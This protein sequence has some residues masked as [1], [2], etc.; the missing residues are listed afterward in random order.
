MMEIMRHMSIPK[1]NIKGLRGRSFGCVLFS[2]LFVVETFETRYNKK[3]AM[4]IRR[5]TWILERDSF[6]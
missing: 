3:N 5:K 6:R 4:R 2:A 1:M